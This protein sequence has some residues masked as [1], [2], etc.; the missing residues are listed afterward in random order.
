MGDREQDSLQKTKHHKDTHI[1]S[2]KNKQPTQ[3]TPKTRKP[4]KVNESNKQT[5]Q[6][7]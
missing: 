7:A 6:K 3:K 4:S 5:Q 1:H 2:P